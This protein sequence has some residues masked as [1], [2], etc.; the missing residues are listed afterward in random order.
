MRAFRRNCVCA[1]GA[2]LLLTFARLGFGGDVVLDVV[3]QVSVDQYRAYEAEIENMGLGLYGGPAYNQGARNRDGYR[4]G[5][6]LGNQEACLYLADQFL[7]MGLATS[8]QGDYRNVVGELRGV[9]APDRIYI[10][11]GHYDT[12]DRGE[13]PGGDDN[14]SG[15]AGVVEAARVLSR[16]R[17]D[18]TLRFIG[19]NAEEDWMWGSQDYVDKV[20]VANRENVLG[21]INLDMILRPAWDSNPRKPIDLE[22]ETGPSAYQFAW[23]NVFKKAAATYTPLLPI[24]PAAPFTTY[25]DA[26]DQGPF[27]AAGYPTV[28]AI[29]NGAMEI[30]SGQANAY[31]HTSQDASDKLANDSASPSGVT[32]DYDFATDVVRAT[33]A[34]LAGQAGIVETRVPGFREVQTLP[35]GIAEDV[36]F[37]AYAGA[38]YLVVANH[39]GSV[40]C[41]VNSIVYKWDGTSFVEYQSIPTKGAADAEFF[42]IGDDAFLAVANMYDGTTYD[43]I[44]RTYK[45]D[46]TRFAEFQTA[47]ER[48]ASDMEFFTIGG[49]A[50]LA[51]ANM[52]ATNSVQSSVVKW[53]GSVFG[54]FQLIRAGAATGLEFFEID[55]TAYL[56][57]AVARDAVS[58]DVKSKILRWDGTRFVDFQSIA[59]YG[60]SDW[61]FFTIAGKSYLAVANEYDGL[62]YDVNSWIYKW[63]GTHFVPY[64]SIPTRGARDW[65]FFTVAGDS[66]LAVANAGGDL[67]RADS[68]VYRWNGMR[69]VEFTSLPVQGVRGWDSLLI[70]GNLYLAAGG[71]ISTIYRYDGPY[72][73]NLDGDTDVD[74]YD[75]A[76]FAAAWRARSGQ[77]GWS[78]ACDISVPADNVVDGRD[79]AVLA[80]HWLRSPPMAAAMP[81]APGLKNPSA[82]R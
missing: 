6:T 77:P 76:V 54:S 39:R 74:L 21:V 1:W 15:T 61:E 60:A 23:V 5:G 41:D 70:D 56:A 64:Q 49:D 22:L 73:G 71:A 10:V 4:G 79:L 59:T 51:T 18:A 82:K 80:E 7:A 48:G 9:R 17:F 52:D 30:W 3:N 47:R 45:W 40:T 46:G 55:G 81:L 58:Y 72:T 34:T 11:G 42:T 36:E 66:C 26:G 33:V 44:S 16:R 31:Y 68:R 29:D 69:F 8:I 2:F 65:H 14:A 63:N 57:I 25:W 24:D 62:T 12:T 43:L 35:A 67:P 28:L 32:Y 37:F 27:I 13:Y 50:F 38:D 20:V 19:F 75:Y 53:D 78:E